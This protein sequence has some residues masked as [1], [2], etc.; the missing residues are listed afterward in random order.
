MKAIGIIGAGNIGKAV[1]TQSL[2]N[3]FLVLISNSKGPE[4]LTA[5]VEKLGTGAKAVTATEAA[6]ADIVVIAVPWT[7]VKDL[8]RLTDWNGKIVID[9]SNRFEQGNGVEDGGLASSEVVQNHLPG[10]KVVKGFN[11][12]FAGVLAGDPQVGNGKRVL[13]ISGDDKDA[14]ATVSA[15]I[16]KIG[17]APIDLG[18]L[19]AGGKLQQFNWPLASKNF[20][21]L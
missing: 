2:A 11:T 4:T 16:G 13:F 8:T 20:V 1:A 10:A 18:P 15:I 6:A 14:K 19:A 21:I 17:F 12:L 3:D 9:A 5:V 7:K